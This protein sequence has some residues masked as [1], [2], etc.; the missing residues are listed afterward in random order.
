MVL[1]SNTILD[2]PLLYLRISANMDKIF[3]IL[4]IIITNEANFESCS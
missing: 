4:L 2:I 3:K 1:D